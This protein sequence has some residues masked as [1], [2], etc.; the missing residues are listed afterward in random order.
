VPLW[1][2]VP[3][4]VRDSDRDL[5]AVRVGECVCVPDGLSVGE[6][7][8]DCVGLA[9][10]RWLDDG[11]G[12]GV[13]SIDFVPV[14]DAVVDIEAVP[15]PEAVWLTL[16]DSVS[17]DVWLKES[18]PDSLLEGT[19]LGLGERDWLLERGCDNDGVVVGVADVL[20]VRVFEG[21]P[22]PDAETLGVLLPL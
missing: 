16:G 3:V 5:D 18:V 6:R 7:L 15:V 12:D 13:G 8:R 11:V 10:T 4:W 19:W 17:D 9:V 14:A 20:A 22:V 1:V 2:G 21:V